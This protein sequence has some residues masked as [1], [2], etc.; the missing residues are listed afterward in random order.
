MNFGF[1]AVVLIGSLRVALR[2]SGR[3]G[4]LVVI[5]PLAAAVDGDEDRLIVRRAPAIAQNF[6]AVGSVGVASTE[7][8]NDF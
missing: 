7:Y 2:G 3:L 6:R 8:A 1:S 4:R 5:E